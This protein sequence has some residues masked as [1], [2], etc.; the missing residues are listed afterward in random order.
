[1]KFFP[2][3]NVEFWWLHSSYLFY[4]FSKYFPDLLKPVN[5]FIEMLCCCFSKNMLVISFN[6]QLAYAFKISLGLFFM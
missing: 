6:I 5:I 4:L 1:M 3:V 2:F